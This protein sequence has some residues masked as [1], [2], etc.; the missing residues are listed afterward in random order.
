MLTPKQLDD[1]PHNMIH[2]YAQVEAVIIADMA[3][4]MSKMDFLPSAQWQYQKLIEMGIT[5]DNIVKELSKALHIS[6]K[7]VENLMEDVADL[8]LKSDIDI[9][10]DVGL[11]PHR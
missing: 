10:E 11:S 8:T 5:H 1:I 6:K 2:L 3:R 4:R 7:E 9:Y